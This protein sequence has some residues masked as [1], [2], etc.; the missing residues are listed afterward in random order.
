MIYYQANTDQLHIGLTSRKEAP[1]GKIIKSDISVAKKLYLTEDELF[2]LERIMSAYLDLAEDRA[3]RHIPMTMEDWL[4][5]LDIFLMA[6]DRKMPEQLQ[7]RLQKPM[8]R[9]NL[10][11]TISSRIDYMRVTM[12][13][14]SQWSR[15]Q[16]LMKTVRLIKE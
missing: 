4:R 7:R 2:S 3:R 16:F 11:D 10:N 15:V 6:D 13:A 12:I 9:A 14:F 8:L 5:R 1:L